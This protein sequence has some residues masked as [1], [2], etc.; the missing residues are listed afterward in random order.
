MQVDEYFGDSG[1]IQH[2]VKRVKKK[3]NDYILNHY[4]ELFGDKP[5]KK[6]D[7][8][9]HPKLLQKAADELR[10]STEIHKPP[11]EALKE[12]IQELEE[13]GFLNSLED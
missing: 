1:L 6:E 7:I 10:L 5:L 13:K 12:C 11:V 2:S 3:L 9:T 8:L 4:L